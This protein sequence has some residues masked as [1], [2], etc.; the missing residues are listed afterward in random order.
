VNA[1]ADHPTRPGQPGGHGQPGQPGGHGQP[2]PSGAGP[3]PGGA[4]SRLDGFQRRHRWA[5][6][7]LAV[8]YKYADD[9]GGYLAALITYYGFVSLFP[10]LLLLVSV[11]GF[12]LHGH[13][14]LQRAFVHSVLGQFPATGAQLA[15]NIHAYHGSVAA[16]AVGLGGAV[17]GG[18]GVAQ[19]AQ[20]ALNRIWAVPRHQRPNPIT[21]RLRS[22]ALLGVL[23]AGV[24][25]T[26][27]LSSLA[28]SGAAYHAQE[29]MAVWGLRAAA[30]GLSVAANVCLFY[31][32]FRVL[33]ARTVRPRNVVPGAVVAALAWQALQAAGTYYAGRELRHA[34]AVYGLFGLVLGLLAWIYAEAV[35]IVVAAE[36]SAVHARRLWPRALLAP[37]T[38]NVA[39]TSAD[40]RAYA[41]YAGAER[42]KGFQQVRV[43]FFARAREGTPRSPGRTR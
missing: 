1:P 7:P 13:P 23:G 10:L 38:D 9:Q 20:N 11:L 21:S 31:L 43:R 27:G 25:A 39:L 17:Y 5:G 37:F 35:V 41:S 2:E 12:V 19:A 33:T 42:Y 36:V 18:L 29:P 34:S 30:T 32:A 14:A 22:L 28:T 4:I 26:T 40:Q 6:F 3:G 16:L 8:A 15:R 24:L